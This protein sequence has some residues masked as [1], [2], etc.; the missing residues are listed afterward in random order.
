MATRSQQNSVALR[1]I[2]DA[3]QLAALDLAIE[4]AT[5]RRKMNAAEIEFF[6][7]HIEA[8]RKRII[9]AADKRNAPHPASGREE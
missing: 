4:I 6:R 8:I 5:G 9:D 3:T 2:S 1:M 7:R